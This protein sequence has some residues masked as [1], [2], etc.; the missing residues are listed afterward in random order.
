MHKFW[1]IFI[2]LN[3]FGFIIS[4]SNFFFMLF[5]PIIFCINSASSLLIYI[6]FR[7]IKKHKVNN[8]LNILFSTILVIFL[9][10]LISYTFFSLDKMS[11]IMIYASIIYLC[12][13]LLMIV[14][15]E[16]AL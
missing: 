4:I 13:Q 8:F 3:I 7:F 9:N 2:G 14:L 5:Y 6:I 16:A 11:Q 12:F 15:L 10:I 1:K